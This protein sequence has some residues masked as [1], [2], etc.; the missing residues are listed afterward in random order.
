M[1]LVESGYQVTLTFAD[2]YEVLSGDSIT[3]SFKL[4]FPMLLA[5]SET[6]RLWSLKARSKVVIEPKTMMFR[7]FVS[8]LR[9]KLSCLLLTSLWESC[10]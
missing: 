7:H 8:V 9:A 6:T 4:S 5:H 1:L 2:D 3:V 10:Q